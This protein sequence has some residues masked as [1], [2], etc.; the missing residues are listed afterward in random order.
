MGWN[1][2]GHSF[3]AQQTLCTAHLMQLFTVYYKVLQILSLWEEKYENIGF[4][5]NKPKS[6]S[7]LCFLAI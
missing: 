3:G 6:K 7:L 4:G 5:V 2:V 1:C